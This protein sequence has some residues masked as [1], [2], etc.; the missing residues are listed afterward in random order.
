MKYRSL[1][2]W[3]G[4]DNT[5]GLIFV[6]QLID[7]LLFDYTLDTYKPSAMNTCLLAIEALNTIKSINKG[8]IKKPNLKHILDE[9]C[10]NLEND[11]VAISLINID[12]NGVKATLKDPKSSEQSINT[13]VELLAIQM[14]LESY[15]KKNEE[16]LYEELTS[17]PS[18]SALRSLTRSYI[19]TLINCGFSTEYIKGESQ[20]FFFYSKNRIGGNDAIKDYFELFSLK[21]QKYGV[22]YKGPKYLLEFQ[23]SAKKLGIDVLEVSP[24]T[25]IDLT[26]YSFRKSKDECFLYINEI[27]S[28]D[29]HSAKSATEG[30]VKLLQTLIGLYHHKEIPKPITECLA[31]NKKTEECRKASTSINPMH[32]CQ[33]MKPGAA[34]KKLYDF[35]SS[36]SMQRESFQK[37]NRSAELH[38]LALSSESRENQMINLWISLESLIPSIESNNS[39]SHIEHISN[40]LVPFLNLGYIN[41]L[42][43]RFSNDLFQ[44]NSHIAK[45][46]LKDIKADGVLNKATHLLVLDE[47]ESKRTKLSNSFRDFHL[48]KNRFE[49]IQ[50]VVSDPKR[51]IYTLDAHK[52]RV[53]WQLRRIYRARNTIVHDGTTPTYVDILI[54]NTHDYLDSIMNS[55]MRLAAKENTLN[56]IEQGFKMVELNY[57]SYY[58]SINEK[59]LKFD[60]NNIDKLFFMNQV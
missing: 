48:L 34:S 42:I 30:K 23:S 43:M 53:D 6:A 16:L 2:K 52:T 35:I 21:P 10:E 12:L 17:Q 57:Y 39:T 56:S 58:K 37:F 41:K 8:T 50:A 31:F 60:S 25:R 5:K 11:K 26:K 55:L 46:L 15:K 24:D 7:E 27:E 54:E 4:K 3:D 32:K 40:S 18:M 22:L 29:I 9:L 49:H 59:G 19:T 38:A 14:P 47:Y 45:N 36:F 1:Q 51:I 13:T 33:D 28:L 44:W 20:K